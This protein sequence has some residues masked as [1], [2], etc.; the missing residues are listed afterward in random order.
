M[1]M[2][3]PG[4]ATSTLQF[5]EGVSICA[6]ALFVFAHCRANCLRECTSASLL[7]IPVHVDCVLS[8]NQTLNGTEFRYTGAWR[9]PEEG[10]STFMHTCR[11][12]LQFVFTVL[13]VVHMVLLQAFLTW[14]TFLLLVP[15]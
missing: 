10:V 12:Q 8:R 2:E 14:T 11:W 13:I 3:S 9:I 4:G 1:A 5:R 15:P 7:L 6:V